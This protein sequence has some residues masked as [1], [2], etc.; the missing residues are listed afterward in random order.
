MGAIGGSASHRGVSS[1]TSAPTLAS[2]TA[3]APSA[4]QR[5]LVFAHSCHS[6]SCQIAVTAVL[7][8]C[9]G[10]ADCNYGT[11]QRRSQRL[12]KHE[13]GSADSQGRLATVKSR[14]APFQVESHRF[15]V[16]SRFCEVDS[17]PELQ[18]EKSTR[19]PSCN[20]ERRL[21]SR[22][23]T[24]KIDSTQGRTTRKSDSTHEA[25]TRK[26]D[27]TQEGTTR[28]THLRPPLSRV[29]P[30]GVDSL[31]R[32]VLAEIDSTPRHYRAPRHYLCS[33]FLHY[34]T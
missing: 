6:C 1:S 19:L 22:V 24:R 12:A 26:V 29:A 4:E 15:E 33:P 16:E 18:L 34:I 32:V 21:D 9:K 25:T 27:S 17:T 23:A 31:R 20:S 13:D 11:R 3:M 28:Q 10:C 14:L 5:S 30:V 8:V 7:T 2:G